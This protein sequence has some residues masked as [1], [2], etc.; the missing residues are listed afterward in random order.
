MTLR[1]P[2][3]GSLAF[4]R[5]VWEV[6]LQA[7]RFWS[8]RSRVREPRTSRLGQAARVWCRL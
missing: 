3:M 7:L 4:L 8:G 6:L 2:P 1:P 5:E